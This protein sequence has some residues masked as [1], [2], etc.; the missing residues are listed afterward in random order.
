MFL[1]MR[2]LILT[3][4]SSLYLPARGSLLKKISPTSLLKIFASLRT[5]TNVIDDTNMGD[6]AAGNV[7]T[8]TDTLAATPEPSAVVLLG[9]GMRGIFF[10]ARR[11][12][13]A[14]VRPS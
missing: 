4:C 14:Q 3:P 11:C 7:D 5:R 9:I 12:R 6:I 2:F 13:E 1:H 10:L 8:F